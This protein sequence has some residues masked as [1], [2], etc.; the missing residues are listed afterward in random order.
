MPELDVAGATL[1]YET[2]GH[3][4]Q[5]ALLLLVADAADAAAWAPQIETSA[6]SHFVIRLDVHTA[7]QAG[8]VLDLLDHLGVLTASAV[9][10]GLGAELARTIAVAHPDRI[11]ALD[12]L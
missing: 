11:T 10:R 12:V 4:S 9:G 7:L 5:P 2:T 1:F 3:I 6:R 8:H